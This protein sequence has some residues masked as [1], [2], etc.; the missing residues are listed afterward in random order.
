MPAEHLERGRERE[1]ERE[2]GRVHEDY[3]PSTLHKYL[4]T[5]HAERES[6]EQLIFY[7]MHGQPLSEASQPG[8][9]RSSPGEP[10]NVPGAPRAPQSGGHSPPHTQ[11]RME[12]KSQL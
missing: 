10:P 1:R 4:P 5:K 7:L 12:I 9:G 6:S 3:K 8:T 2:K 11:D